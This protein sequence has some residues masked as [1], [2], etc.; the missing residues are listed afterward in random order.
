MHNVALVVLDTLRKDAFTRHFEWLPGRRFENAWAP[1]HWTVP[2]HASMFTGRYPSEIGVYASAERLDCQDVVL[3][4]LLSAAGYTTRAFST[5]GNV[6]SHFD[7]DR[8]FDVFDVNWRAEGWQAEL[9]LG[10]SRDVFDWKRFDADSEL[11][12]GVHSL[13]GHVRSVVGDYD[14]LPSVRHWWGRK[15][16]GPG[17]PGFDESHRDFG[18]MEALE[19][20]ESQ[21]FADEGEFCFLNL[22]E[23]HNP[24]RPPGE[25]QTV[26]PV[27]IHGLRAC[28]DGPDPEPERVRTAYDDS[29]RYLADVYERIFEVLVADFDYVLT[30]S[31]HGELLGEHDRWEH[32]C[33]IYPELTHVPLVV[34]GTGGG[35]TDEMAS[36]RDLYRTISGLAG[37]DPPERA[38][39]RDILDPETGAQQTLTEYHGLSPLH[40]RSLTDDELEALRSLDTE[41]HGV[42]LP[43]DYYG[44]ETT[45]E[46]WNH[47]GST[48]DDPRARL[49]DLVG[50]LD[51]RP[52]DEEDYDEL[53]DDVLNHLEDLG[54]V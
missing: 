25:Y 11:P 10:R 16:R 45:E 3:A 50:A 7:Y 42:L 5:N 13:V 53:S 52:V 41:L 22:M 49:V 20:V 54:Y 40:V 44:Y 32:L 51:R 23:A 18:A 17:S 34:T 2:V 36:L 24:Y 28:V 33:G 1:S 15:R 35:T 29:V 31:D 48:D 46:E 27:R 47:C 30:V 37:V 12:P 19:W 21:Q 38:G 14:V 9:E 43:P 6:S 26:E 8:G 39:G 4:E